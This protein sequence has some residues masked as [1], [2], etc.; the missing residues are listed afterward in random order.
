VS[1]AYRVFCRIVELLVL[2]GRRERS[3]DVEILVLRHQ[4][5]VLRRQN[6]R[7]R[8]D[9]CDRMVLAGLSRVL[10]RKRWTTAFFVTPATLLRWHRRLVVRHW[11]YPKRRRGRRPISAGLRALIV[12]IASENP[13]WGYRRIHGE[14]IGLGHTVAAS[15]VWKLLRDAGIDPSPRRGQSWQKFLRA[16]ARHVIACDFF[17]VDT[18]MLRRYYVLFFF[19]L[20]TRRVDIAGITKHPTGA[21]TTQQARNIVDRFAGTRR[22]LIRDR[23]AKFEAA[24]DMIFVSEQITIIKT[25]VRAPVANAFAER[26]IGTVRREC[27]DRILILGEGHLRR[28]I[29]EYVQHYNRH[30]PHRS[31]QQRTPAATNDSDPRCAAALPECRHLRRD[32]ILGA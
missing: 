27:L 9:D 30:R 28:V 18:V 1:L 31:L 7:P 6:P 14:V 12:R 4:L 22:F 5:A 26:W 2:R 29:H 17:T 24:F 16:Q 23:D 13:T 25:P 11:T 10:D 15:T 20:D 3:K 32:Q 19:E 8:L 21:W